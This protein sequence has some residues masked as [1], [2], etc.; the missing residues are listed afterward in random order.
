M[1][2]FG[3][4]LATVPDGDEDALADLLEERIESVTRARQ[5]VGEAVR[6]HSTALQDAEDELAAVLGDIR[7]DLEASGVDAAA[8]STEELID[9]ANDD[10]VSDATR[11]RIDERLPELRQSVAAGQRTFEQVA[12]AL[13]EIQAEH[14]LCQR[15]ASELSAGETDPASAGEQLRSFLAGESDY[16]DAETSVVDVVIDRHGTA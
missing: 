2:S 7:S 16:G 5:L 4:R 3:E 11:E 10:E 6:S 9:A 15:L 12:P 8:Y 14:A 1:T 13:R